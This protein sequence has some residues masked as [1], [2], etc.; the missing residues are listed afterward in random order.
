MRARQLV[1]DPVQPE[2]S[3]LSEVAEVLRTGG[4]I[5]FPTDTSYGLGVNPY[6]KAAVNKVYKLKGRDFNNPLLLLINDIRQLDELAR[7]VSPNTWKLIEDFWPG[8]LTLIL[9]ANEKLRK[10]QVGSSG[11]VGV[12][13]P[14]NILAR[15]IVSAVEFPVTATSANPS[16]KPSVFSAREVLEYFPDNLDVIVDGGAGLRG[17]EST[18]VDVTTEPFKLIRSGAVALDELRLMVS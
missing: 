9:H 17:K 8:P 6:N 11:K 5:A 16:G 13:L 4:V 2:H 14:D 1:I 10:F 7:D 18:I 15:A 3:L 12:R